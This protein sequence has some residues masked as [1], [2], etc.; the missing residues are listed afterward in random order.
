MWRFNSNDQNGEMLIERMKEYSLSLVFDAKDEGTFRSKA[1][2][3]EYP[4]LF[5][6]PKSSKSTS[7]Y[8]WKIYHTISN[9]QPYMKKVFR[10]RS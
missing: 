6:N 5:P 7:P 2:N 10:F 3:R 4:D 1:Y 9:V 8:I